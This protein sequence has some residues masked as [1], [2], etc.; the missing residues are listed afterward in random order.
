MSYATI[1]GIDVR[2]LVITHPYSGAWM[3]HVVALSEEDITGGV[4]L[5][6]NGLTY[7]GTV[8]RGGM[9]LKQWEGKIIG[10]LGL[11]AAQLEGKF[12]DDV[13]AY[14][15]LRDAVTGA[16]ESLADSSDEEALKAVSLKQW[17]RVQRTLGVELSRI[18]KR[19]GM[20]WRILRDGT[21]WMGTDAW[22][23]STLLG[24]Q[25]DYWPA[26][27]KALYVPDA[28]PDLLPGQ[29]IDGRHVSAV[30]LRVDEG[31]A[32]LTAMLVEGAL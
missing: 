21:V 10:G 31:T 18:A 6:V 15:A 12:F 24:T 11:L 22:E 9:N 16:G 17:A 13:T 29:S 20:V 27:G 14:L 2:E 3:A 8:M 32:R 28:A 5:V 30:E 25:L 23:E 26:R 7:S 1:N 19:S 4:E